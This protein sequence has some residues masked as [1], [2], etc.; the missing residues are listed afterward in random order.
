MQTINNHVKAPGLLHNIIKYRTQILLRKMSY[1]TTPL[2]AV[3]QQRLD[4]Q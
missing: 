1:P 3:P 2:K 4:M